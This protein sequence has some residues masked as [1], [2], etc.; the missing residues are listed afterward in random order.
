MSDDSPNP[1]WTS[2]ASV[3]LRA[4]ALLGMGVAF[5]LAFNQLR[6]K[7]FAFTS[8]APPTTCAA[9]GEEHEPA[10]RPIEVLV[11]EQVAAL[12]GVPGVAFADVRDK[13]KYETGHVIQAHHLPCTASP[14]AAKVAVEVL[15]ATNTVVVYGE[16]TEDA[17]RVADSLREKA[18]RPELRVIVM[19]GGF[20]AWNEA[21]LACT[22]GACD[23]CGEAKL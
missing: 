10:L 11:P 9:V 18:A 20:N 15:A 4:V 22:S 2:P 17:A 5:G 21:G 13:H 16:T 8:W 3:G 12:C 1:F 6:P 14:D 7:S 23:E 19:S